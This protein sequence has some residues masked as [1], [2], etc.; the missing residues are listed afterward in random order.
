[1]L[2][3]AAKTYVDADRYAQA[4]RSALGRIAQVAKDGFRRS[5]G[6]SVKLTAL[7]PRYEFTREREAVAAV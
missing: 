1:M 5:P 6:I 7:H 4:Y 3:E 2:G